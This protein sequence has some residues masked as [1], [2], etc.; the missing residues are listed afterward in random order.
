MALSK[1]E[2]LNLIISNS[3][4]IN[5]CQ[6]SEFIR[7]NPELFQIAIDGILV[8]TYVYCILCKSLIK[9]FKWSTGHLSRHFR[10]DYHIFKQK[11]SQVISEQYELAKRDKNAFNW[12]D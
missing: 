3:E 2:I 5:L 4:R 6:Y 1:E 7:N 12:T 9:K 10:T 8:S 11:K